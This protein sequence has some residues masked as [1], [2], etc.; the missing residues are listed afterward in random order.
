MLL[1]STL[2]ETSNVTKYSLY[3]N[4]GAVLGAN[5]LRNR[6]SVIIT[7]AVT[8]V[9]QPRIV[10]LSALYFG[11]KVLVYHAA[12]ARAANSVTLTHI[13][14]PSVMSLIRL[15][16]YTNI[17]TIL[18]PIASSLLALS[19]CFWLTLCVLTYIILILLPNA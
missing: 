5:K 18:T 9:Q 11:L 15:G 13:D 12:N 19:S 16:Y 10:A 14:T 7:C 6:H 4:I 3:S 8:H 1:R 17:K 2:F